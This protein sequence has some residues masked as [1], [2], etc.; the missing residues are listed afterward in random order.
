MVRPKHADTLPIGSVSTINTRYPAWP[1]HAATF[2]A[3]AVFP[4]P[5]FWLANRI[6]RTAGPPAD[7]PGADWSPPAFAAAGRTAVRDAD[8]IR[9]SYPA[10][11][12]PGLHNR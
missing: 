4:T 7:L 6:R 9:V 12:C 11:G 10:N 5:P 2:T 1:R 3:V 8:S